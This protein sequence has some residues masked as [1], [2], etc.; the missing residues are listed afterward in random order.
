[1]ASDPGWVL[2]TEGKYLPEEEPKEELS[3]VSLT[4]CQVSNQKEYLITS[5]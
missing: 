1:M 5:I 3:L 2:K 4:R